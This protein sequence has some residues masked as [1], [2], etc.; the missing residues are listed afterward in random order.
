MAG[1]FTHWV[2]SV[3]IMLAP[4]PGDAYNFIL[5]LISYPLSVIN[6][7]IAFGLIWLTIFHKKLN[8][9]PQLNAHFPLASFSFSVPFIWLLR[10]TFHPQ[11]IK[12][13]T[14]V[15]PTGFTVLSVSVC[16]WLAQF[17]GSSDILSF[18]D[19]SPTTSPAIVERHNVNEFGEEDDLQDGVFIA[20]QTK[21]K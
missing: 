1:L 14:K 15:Y 4:P 11:V 21:M 10:H 16:L 7:A 6:A 19:F 5:N 9:N 8:W 3:I 2:V 17:T 12:A 20:G 18:L 13:F